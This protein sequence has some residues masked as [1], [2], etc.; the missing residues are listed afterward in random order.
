[1]RIQME[2]DVASFF[3]GETGARNIR[4]GGGGGGEKVVREL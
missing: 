4:Y 3:M 1:M 2:R